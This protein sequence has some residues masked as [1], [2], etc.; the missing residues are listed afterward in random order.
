MW[1]RPANLAPVSFPLAALPTSNKVTA[2]FSFFIGLKGPFRFGHETL[3]SIHPQVHV[4]YSSDRLSHTHTRTHMVLSLTG[5]RLSHLFLVLGRVANTPHD[6][7]CSLGF[8][9]SCLLNYISERTTMLT[10]IV[11]RDSDPFQATTRQTV[12]GRDVGMVYFL[13]CL[14]CF[15]NVVCPQALKKNPKNSIYS[16]CLVD[17]QNCVFALG[18]G[19]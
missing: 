2:H 6:K 14:V 7:R 4:P 19:C 10:G 17:M 8:N 15:S 1:R 5:L 16:M 3:C 11:K 12:E 18:Q 13:D 9:H